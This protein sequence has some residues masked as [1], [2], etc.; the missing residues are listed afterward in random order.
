M[1]T[2]QT[3]TYV[4]EYNFNKG[5]WLKLKVLTKPEKKKG[6]NNAVKLVNDIEKDI[7][8]LYVCC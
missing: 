7:K 8:K 6:I 1:C 3:S 4:G 2:V 5:K